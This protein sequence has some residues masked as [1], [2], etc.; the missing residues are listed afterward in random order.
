MPSSNAKDVGSGAEQGFVVRFALLMALFLVVGTCSARAAS[1]VAFALDAS[2]YS[3]GMEQD[4]SAS[5]AEE[6]ALALCRNKAK[7]ETTASRCKIEATLPEGC[8]AVA[9]GPAWAAWGGGNRELAEQTA[10]AACQRHSKSCTVVATTCTDDL[11]PAS[12]HQGQVVEGRGFR[13]TG[14]NMRGEHGFVG[15]KQAYNKIWMDFVPVDYKVKTVDLAGSF[16]VQGASGELGVYNFCIAGRGV[17]IY[18]SAGPRRVEYSCT[19]PEQICTLGSCRKNLRGPTAVTSETS[20]SREGD[21]VHLRGKA[22]ATYA[23]GYIQNTQKIT[24][25]IDF[26]IEKDGTCHLINYRKESHSEQIYLEK[27]PYSHPEPPDTIVTQS[28]TSAQCDIF[29]TP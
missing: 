7:N 3:F 19:G 1:S 29:K 4:A 16:A 25:E 9:A 6:K 2:G 27:D 8:V 28:E 11:P 22:T 14:M 21:M 13:F 5:V 18:D 20:F 26:S 12:T 23:V 15:N 24:E 17:L 10:L